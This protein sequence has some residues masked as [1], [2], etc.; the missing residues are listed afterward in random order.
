MFRVLPVVVLL[1]C[2]GASLGGWQLARGY[3]QAET[4]AVLSADAAQIETELQNRFSAYAQVLYGGAGLFAA[5]GEVTRAEWHE[6]FQALKLA[7]RFPGFQGLAYTQLL[8]PE[9]VAA[10]E[11]AV[12]AEGFPDYHVRPPG[13][14]ETYTAI[15][16]IEPFD[17]RN[18]R[19]FGFDMYSEPVRRE[20]MERAR[21]TG[22]AALSGKVV[23]VQEDGIDV[24]RGFL[25]Y[26][27]VYEK[28]APTETV[29]ERRAALRGWV[30]APFRARDFISGLRSTPE[31]TVS[32]QVYDGARVEPDALLYDSGRLASGSAERVV[33]LDFAGRPW[34]LVERP[35][36][37]AV[38]DSLL[39]LPLA[40]LGTGIV[41]SGLLFTITLTLV[42]TRERATRLAEEKTAELR[43]RTQELEASNQALRQFSYV[44]T[45]DLKEPVRGIDVYLGVLHDDHRHE[46]GDDARALLESAR[47][48]T[49]RLTRLLGALLELS[50][51]DRAQLAVGRIDPAVVLRSEQCRIAYET[52]QR[53]RGARVETGPLPHVVAA[54]SVLAQALG[55]LVA[56]AIRHNTDAQPRVLVHGREAAGEVEILIEDNGAGF[57]PEQ[58]EAYDA[59]RLH[60]AGFGLLLARQS[61]ERLGGRMRLGRSARLGGAC[62]SLTLPAAAPGAAGPENPVGG[63]PR[64][65]G[66]SSASR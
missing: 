65:R 55:N 63:P 66:S 2:L 10:H 15:T 14:R 61:V 62:V 13:A 1:A 24:Q 54:A 32:L 11:A 59:G 34:T 44:V 56:N 48:A 35:T 52:L 9:D 47:A 19:A 41:A 33:T 27:P 42:T 25:L 58:L 37:N 64:T 21:D 53:E 26:V 51:A 49:A 17:A 4:G 12:R 39:F 31:A 29:E 22:G 45:H 18:Q 46:L 38:P 20:A 6:Y 8:A 50:R 60:G 40:V 43:G 5:S 30:Y 7:D 3:A 36:A 23:L 28:G 57:P 16:Y